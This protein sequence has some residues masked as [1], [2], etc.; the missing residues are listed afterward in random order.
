MK[1]KS[2]IRRIRNRLLVKTELKTPFCAASHSP[3]TGFFSFQ[4]TDSN[5]EIFDK[6]EN[7][8]TPVAALDRNTNGKWFFLCRT[9][10]FSVPHLIEKWVNSHLPHTQAYSLFTFL[11]VSHYADNQ[12][13]PN[14]D[15]MYRKVRQTVS[16]IDI[17]CTMYIIQ[18]IS[19]QTL[20][21]VFLET[22][23]MLIAA[24]Q[25]DC[26]DMVPTRCNVL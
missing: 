18:W 8:Q 22:S 12:I 4:L 15:E 13:Q 26:S 3:P 21:V 9:C 14:F 2:S 17:Y 7:F 11:I 23:K 20:N 1:F 10:S 5:L 25:H 24:R 19:T 16:I 6:N